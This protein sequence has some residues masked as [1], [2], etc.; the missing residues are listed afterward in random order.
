MPFGLAS[1]IAPRR[2]PS[3]LTGRQAS[4]L[5]TNPNVQHYRSYPLE[6]PSRP[7]LRRSL[8]GRGSGSPLRES[9][10]Q[11]FCN[12]RVHINEAKRLAAGAGGHLDLERREPHVALERGDGVPARLEPAPRCDERSASQT[13][14][15][16]DEPV[17]VQ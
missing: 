15:L 16:E 3:R 10:D 9:L 11:A 2:A 13:P 8:P 6:S 12:L 4:Y 5:A 17:I 7:Q 14:K 1:R